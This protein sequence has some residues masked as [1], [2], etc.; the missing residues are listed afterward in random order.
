MEALH[1]KYLYFISPEVW[2]IVCDGV[3]F[4]EDDE[5]LTLEQLQKIYRNAQAITKTFPV[6]CHLF[7]VDD[8]CIEFE[9]IKDVS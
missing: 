8:R 6:L 5:E 2:Q 9:S 7:W 3:V 1:E 4:L